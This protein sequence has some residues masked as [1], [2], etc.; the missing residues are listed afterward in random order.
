MGTRKLI[1]ASGS[2]RR[3]EILTRQGIEFEIIKS[4][5]EES[6]CETDP[7]RI[8]MDLSLQKAEDVFGMLGTKADSEEAFILAADTIVTVDNRVLGKPQDKADAFRMI[9]SLQ[10]REH[11]VYTGVT[12]IDG[13]GQVQVSF[14]ECTKVMLYPMSDDEINAYIA[15]GEP[16]DKAGAYGIQGCFAVHVR[17]IMGDYDNVVGLP[18]ARLYQECRRKG[19]WPIGQMRVTP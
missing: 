19:I 4:T 8:V 18:V 15:T 12:V 6:T 14:A 2:P 3:K 1:L 17:G 9:E 10:G 7:G 11:E 5:C 13:Q 16:M